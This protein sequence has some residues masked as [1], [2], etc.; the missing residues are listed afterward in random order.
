M[1]DTQKDQPAG[2]GDTVKVN[3]TGT[4]ENG[5]VFAS[6]LAEKPL[7]FTIGHHDVIP[8]MEKA[9]VGMKPGESK[10]T[11]ITPVDGFGTYRPELAFDLSRRDIPPEIDAKLN[12]G[13][14][15]LVNLDSRTKIPA[16][17]MQISDD[18]VLLNANHP[19]A[20]QNMKL[21]LELLE[22]L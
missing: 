15:F 13:S 2:Q 5:E 21:D 20:G 10:S 4:L 1:T 11:R 16:C 9:V 22:I 12:V 3:F 14:E 7:E 17:V 6:T 19:L 18:R 8:G